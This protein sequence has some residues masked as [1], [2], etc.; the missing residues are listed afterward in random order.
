MEDGKDGEV[1]VV[2]AKRECCT[3]LVIG[4]KAGK[5]L[6]LRG[7]TSIESDSKAE[8]RLGGSC[9]DV[10]EEEEEEEDEGPKRLKGEVEDEGGR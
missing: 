4:V 5:Q 9:G 2:V 7:V 6:E 3:P 10:E 1:D 8:T